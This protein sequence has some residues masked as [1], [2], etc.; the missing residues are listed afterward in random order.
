MQVAQP[1]QQRKESNHY[2]RYRRGNYRCYISYRQITTIL[3]TKMLEDLGTT[4]PEDVAASR[5]VLD[6]IREEG[7]LPPKI[8]KITDATED[9]LHQ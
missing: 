4:T 6:T 7:Q 5:A 8:T 2:P 1:D 3:E 9:L